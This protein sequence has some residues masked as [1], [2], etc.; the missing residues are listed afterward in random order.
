MKEIYIHYNRTE[1]L[2]ALNK[3][4]NYLKVIKELEK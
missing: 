4:L 3:R 1:Q 2:E